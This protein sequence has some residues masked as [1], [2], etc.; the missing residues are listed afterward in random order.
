MSKKEG[1]KKGVDMP[2]YMKA[3]ELK[4]ECSPDTNI[5]WI[6]SRGINPRKHIG[7]ISVPNNSEYVHV[8][9]KGVAFNF[10]ETRYIVRF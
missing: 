2:I 8:T 7:S 5:L 3:N 1:N 6:S 4:I 10:K 9:R